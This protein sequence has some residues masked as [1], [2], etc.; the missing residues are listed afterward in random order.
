MYQAFVKD[1]AAVASHTCTATGYLA[2]A[3]ASYIFFTDTAPFAKRDYLV[4]A[5]PKLRYMK[6]ICLGLMALSLLAVSCKDEKKAEPASAAAAVTTPQKKLTP[7][8]EQKAWMDYATPGDMHKWMAKMNGTWDGDI[9]MWMNPDSPAI[10]T[11]GQAEYSMILNGL[12]QQGVHKGNMMG[13]P[14]EGRSTMAYD[15]SKKVFVSTWIDNM[16]SGVMTM[17]GTYDDKTK[18]LT[19][20]GK[21]VDPTAGGKEVDVRE[22]VT[23][24]DDNT[25]K[26]EMYC[27]KDGKEMKT[28]EMIAKRKK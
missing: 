22:V 18:M 16:G 12:Y 21:M 5:K 14:F 8:E 4:F 9:T 27:T 20:K 13:M 15:N 23:M 28:M 24:V 7:A 17:E 1:S 6:K 25:Q 10:K 11:K 26:M 3:G 19:S 2:N